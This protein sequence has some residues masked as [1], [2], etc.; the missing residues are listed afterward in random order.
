M[1]SASRMTGTSRVRLPSDFSTS[2]A[3]PRPTWSWRITRGLPSSPLTN[4]E[5]MT[6]TLPAM[7]LTMA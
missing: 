5:L 7:A 6:G 2:T 4:V 1:V 3:M